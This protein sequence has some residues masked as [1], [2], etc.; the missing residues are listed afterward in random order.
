MRELDVSAA[1]GS[2]ALAARGR[3]KS[4]IGRGERVCLARLYQWVA[5][6]R[7]RGARLRTRGA[8]SLGADAARKRSRV[9]TRRAAIVESATRS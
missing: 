9:A 4:V 2:A 3:V 8:M 7:G 6:Q 5:S 1:E